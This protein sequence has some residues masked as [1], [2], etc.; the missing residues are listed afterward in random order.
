MF[1][2]VI[3]PNF[4]LQAALRFREEMHARPVA[5]IDPH[6]PKAGLLEIT[7]T[8]EAAGITT[9]QT[10]TQALA[11]CSALTRAGTNCTSRVA[12]NRGHTFAGS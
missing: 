5:L 7:A 11:R 2:V 8:A 3:L 9:G 6:E 10:A 12:G 1:A 4:R